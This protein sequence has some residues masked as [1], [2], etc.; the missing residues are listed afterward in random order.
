MTTENQGFIMK[1]CSKCGIKKNE[2]DF[3]KDKSRKDGLQP[4]CKECNKL[5]SKAYRE[6]NPDKKKA[7]NKAYYEANPDKKKALNEAWRKTNPEYNKQY[8]IIHPEKFTKKG[9]RFFAT[10]ICKS[11]ILERDG[12]TCQM[13]GIN[14]EL[15]LHHILP[16][17]HDNDS[18]HILNPKNM[19]ILCSEC[20]LKAH[21]GDWKRLDMKIAK[22]LINLIKAK[23]V[24]KPTLLPE[25]KEEPH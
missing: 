14:K 13:C 8:A 1:K 7:S 21:D 9:A 6:A 11:I 25:Y 23:E 3:S 15:E 17:K 24:I 4:K 5:E 12:Y 20:H 18:K 10:F 22:Q 2:S 16:A 19:V